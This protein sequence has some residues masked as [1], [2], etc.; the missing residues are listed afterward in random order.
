MRVILQPKQL[1]EVGPRVVI[2]TPVAVV[3]RR[4]RVHRL[5]GW[6]ADL[7]SGDGSGIAT[8]HVWAYPVDGGAPVFLGVAEN[9]LARPDVA[10]AFGDQ[11]ESTG[12]RLAVHGLATR[13]ATISPSSPGAQVRAGFAPAAVVRVTVR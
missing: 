12:Y 1:G 2:D 8:V 9:G 4:C 5:T 10:A 7:E 3:R 11:F 6:A 13:A